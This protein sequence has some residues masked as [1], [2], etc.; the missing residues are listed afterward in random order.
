[1]Q[2]LRSA[3]VEFHR[4]RDRLWVFAACVILLVTVVLLAPSLNDLKF[5]PARS[6]SRAQDPIRIAILSDLRI[7]PETSV[8]EILLLWLAVFVPLV[9]AVLLLPPELRKKILQQIVRFALF[10]LALVLALRYQL[11][12][13]PEIGGDIL[14]DRGAGSPSS[15]G[16]PQSEAFSPGGIPPW[17]AYAISIVL[18]WLLGL[19]L[20]VALRSWKKYSARRNVSLGALSAIARVSLDDLASGRNWGDVVVEA[21]A[22]MTDV[23]RVSRGLA[24]D[25]A[26]T[27]REFASR[28]A[29]TGLPASAI[30]ELTGLFEAARYGA[31]SSNE[32]ARSRAAACLETILRA[33]EATA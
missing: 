28:L 22:R 23:L 21:Y 11:I 2:V 17:L 24:R 26:T 8:W 32:A 29:R 9:V 4:M 14:P 19:G 12:H 5:E 20:Y 31:T 27:A 30:A 10:V 15:P 6:L 7:G 33:C 1:M 16:A 3:V 25:P 13:L 18:L